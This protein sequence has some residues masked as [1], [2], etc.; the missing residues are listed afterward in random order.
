MKRNPK[1]ILLYFVSG[2]ACV[3]VCVCVGGDVRRGGWVRKAKYSKCNGR[4]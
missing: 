3:C 4:L 2:R 1:I